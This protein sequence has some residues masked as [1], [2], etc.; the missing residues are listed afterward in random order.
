MGREK[1]DRRTVPKKGG[2]APGGKATTVSERPK[3]LGLFT[4]TA[5]N[6]QGANATAVDGLLS[7]AM[8]EVPEAVDKNEIALAAMTMEEIANDGNLNTA[9]ARV[10]DNKGAPGVDR[11]TID[12]VGEHWE[13]ILPA[14]RQS[15]LDGSY[16]VGMIRRV[17][18]PKPGGG[19]R[20]LGI[21]NVI[22]R[23]V[24]QATYQVL[25]P[26]YEV[27]FHGSSHGFRPGRSCHTAISEAAA[28]V[29][30]GYEWVVD[31]DLAQFFDRVHHQRLLAR[32]AQRIADK[33]V[34]ALIHQMLKA[35]VVL[36]DGVVVSSE[37][38][39]PQGGPLSPLLSNIVLDELDQELSQRGHKFVRYADDCNI[40]VRS[41]RAGERVMA[42]VRRFIEKRLRLQ[43]NESKSAVARPSE[44]HFVGFRL[45]VD[46]M[47]MEVEVLLSERSKDRIAEKI[48]T[49]TPR[50]WGGSI[51]DCIKRIN[52]YLRGWIGFFWVCTE[53]ELRTLG[54][55]S[56]HVRRRLR[57]IILKQWKRKR[58]IAKRLIKHGV[59][60][61]RA[62]RS[63]YRGHKRLWALSHC[64]AVDRGLNN[65]YF[66]QLGL[67]SLP[68]E[69]ER[70][71]NRHIDTSQ[72]IA[73]VQAGAGIGSKTA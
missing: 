12:E 13:E 36:P 56:A 2:N 57:A 23:I 21:P 68:V 44:R 52:A 8:R 70:M 73:E 30:E 49:L 17:W 39:T 9:F 16:R 59:R 66:A 48:K 4:A 29:E 24:Q 47:T 28:H 38:G 1:S 63:V 71:R 10:Q 42:S 72:G 46:P 26:H 50:N 25:S 54:S 5:D 32:L 60:P 65:A 67:V 35:K 51:R 40:Y 3:Q 18:I 64:P 43:V 20:G 31:L 58:T 34:L 27:T 7:S 45:N 37:E 14:L 33:R 61:R 55:L 62:W 19:Q 11:Q 69:W 41:Q 6:P 15:L 22:D 53:G